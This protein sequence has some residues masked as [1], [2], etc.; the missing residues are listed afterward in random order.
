VLK[1]A[2]DNCLRA[3]HTTRGRSEQADASLFE[4]KIGITTPLIIDIVG[5]GWVI[6]HTRRSL[7]SDC[8]HCVSLLL[9]QEF[10]LYRSFRIAVIVLVLTVGKLF[11]L[12][13][14]PTVVCSFT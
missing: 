7:C 9:L 6:D 5:G 14:I 4:K 10:R 8:V 12:A 3:L 2:S 13:L 11:I 1:I